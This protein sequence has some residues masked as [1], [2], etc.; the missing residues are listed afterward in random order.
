MGKNCN[1]P[2][3]KNGFFL[4]LPAQRKTLGPPSRLDNG[5]LL[6]RKPTDMASEFSTAKLHSKKI[7]ELILDPDSA[8]VSLNQERN[9]L[10][11]GN[12]QA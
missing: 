6:R 1:S 5:V 3:V 8:S 2:D 10:S 4:L 9:Y 11:S 12:K 7:P